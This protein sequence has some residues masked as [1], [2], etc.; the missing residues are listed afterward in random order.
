LAEVPD[1]FI[2]VTKTPNLIILPVRK[3]V[4]TSR[5]VTPGNVAR[6]FATHRLAAV[7]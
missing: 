4:V 5:D 6:L 2:G 1:E 3:R 7:V